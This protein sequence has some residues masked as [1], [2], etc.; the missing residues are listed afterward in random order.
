VSAASPA[1][2]LAETLELDWIR[3]G[4][5][6]LGRWAARGLGIYLHDRQLAV[7]EQLAKGESVYHF[8]WW[9]NRA[10]KTTLLI[11]LHLW[12]LFYRVGQP[13]PASDSEYERQWLVES[14]RTLHTAPLNALALR[15]WE[16]AAD[17]VNGASRAQ[18]DEHGNRREAPLGPF[19]A[20]TSSADQFGASH[21]A[22]RCL[23]GAVTDFRSTE[24][25]GG[26]IEGGAWRFITWDEWCQQE[27]LDQ[28]RVV[29]TRLTNRGADY[30][31]KLVITGTI[32]EEAEHIAKEW[33]SL[34]EDPGTPD[35]WGISAP[36]YANPA[37]SRRYVEV[38]ARQMSA[39]DY[40]RTVEG[41]PGGVRGRAI[42][43]HLV[44][45]LFDPDLPRFTPPPTS[46]QEKQRWTYV[47]AWDLAIS[48]AENVGIV[49][50]APADWRFG[51]RPDGSF[52]PLVG[53]HMKVIPGSQTLTTAEI[54]HAIE[55]TYLPY[56]GHLVV[57]ATDA[58][59]KGIARELRAAGFPVEPYV[60]N[61]RVSPKMPIRKEQALERARELLAEGAELLRGPDGVVLTDEAGVPLMDWSKPYGV[62][63]VPRSWTKLRD[64][65][66]ALRP[67][68]ERQRK[69]AAMA[70]L[71]AC[72]V[73]WRRRRGSEARARPIQRL[74]VFGRE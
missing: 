28:I 3:D 54:I 43:P 69:D 53:V 72:D 19:F 41:Q 35:W 27:N 45:A 40:R 33:I 64:Q 31:A 47:H 15:A 37:T 73:A 68:D 13:V 9:A 36:R 57:D 46:E 65:L 62:I 22:I 61:E 49:L 12:H 16:A 70:F 42:P 58:F 38:A 11:V 4:R 50:R 60:F 30:E 32:T 7:A 5:H 67:D 21:P 24:G 48:A 20:A 74:T 66:S 10:G 2:K 44:D 63:R 25:G 55:E 51:R 17:I 59:G 71:M 39:E 14:Y 18:R 6:D 26:R 1:S 8:L 29:L 56:G 23:N 34:C 52:E